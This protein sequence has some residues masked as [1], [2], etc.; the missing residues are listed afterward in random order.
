[1]GD[2]LSTRALN[3]ALLERQLLLR[4]AK[5]SAS[6]TIEKLVGMQA[7]EPGDPYVGLWTRLEGFRPEELAELLETRQAVRASM[8]R[9]TIHLFTALDYLSLRPVLRSMLERWLFTSPF[10]RALDGIDADELLEAGRALLNEQPRSRAELGRLLAEHWPDRD[11]GSLA[12]VVLFL[13]PVVQATPRGVWG[14]RSRP[15]WITAE[16]WLGH[17]F[18]RDSSPDELLRRY[19]AA[20]GPASVADAANWS[21]LTGLREVFERLRPGL[22][23]FRDSNGREL[24]DVPRAPLPDP[25]TP[26]PPRFLPV[27]DNVFLGHADRSRIR[28]FTYPTRESL[29]RAAVLVDGFLR[30][31]WRIERHKEAAHL[32]IDPADRLSKS[33]RAALTEEGVGLLDLLASEARTRD[34]RI[35]SRKMG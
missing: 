30:A 28:T 22:R 13:L 29:G 27:Y 9:V 19:L 31:T 11:A 24:F 7:Q 14:K 25:D 6:K 3:R 26:A 33:E 20:F 15:A 23:T 10:G 18:G 4:R 5:L 1:M 16:A 12:S 34:V 21:R 8:M 35:E 32:M 2:V 17:P